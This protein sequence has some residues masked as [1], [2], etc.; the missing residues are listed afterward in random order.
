[1]TADRSAALIGVFVGGD[2]WVNAMDGVATQSSA[3]DVHEG[4]NRN[5][6]VVARTVRLIMEDA[7]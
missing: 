3:I 1:M 5:V 2:V 4:A 7:L 6:R